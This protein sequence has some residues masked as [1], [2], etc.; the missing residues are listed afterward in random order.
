MLYFS[1]NDGSSGYEVWNSNGTTEGTQL[2]ANIA[3][4]SASSSPSGITWVNNGLFFA[5]TM[6]SIGDEIYFADVTGP[7]FLGGSAVYDNASYS[8]LT[9]RRNGLNL[10]I[11]DSASN[12]VVAAGPLDNISKLQVINTQFA[13][14]SLT[15]DYSGGVFSTPLTLNGVNGGNDSLNIIG[16]TGIASSYVPGGNELGTATL[17][18]KNG[19]VQHSIVFDNFE[20]LSATGMF[21]LS[22]EGTLNI[23]TRSFN[24]GAVAPLNLRD[25]TQIAGGTLTATGTVALGSGELI[26]GSGNIAGRFAGESGSAILTTGNLTIGNASSVAGFLTRGELDAGTSTVTLLDSNQAV[27]GSLTSLG[28]ATTIGTLVAANGALIDF[29][30]N[31]IGYGT[32]NTPNLVAKQTTINGSV[33]GTSVANPITLAGYVKG[34]G[35]LNN[36]SVTGTYSPGFSPAAVTLGNVSYAASS[37]TRH[38]AGGYG[39]RHRARPAQPYRPSP[40]R[41]YAR[42]GVD[43]WLPAG[44]RQ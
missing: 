10:E 27:L 13:S 35:S 23:G 5:A 15:V 1:A 16:T 11:V 17:V 34:V 38:R 41:W 29:G 8:Q 21:S 20:S 9:L 37:V 42:S 31:L 4:G 22:V 3:I 43:Q 26:F 12:V 14:S 33:E 18:I 24:V 25:L 6:A 2:F 28:N 39:S 19:A 36:V 44:A 32:L 7:R 30:N 40:S